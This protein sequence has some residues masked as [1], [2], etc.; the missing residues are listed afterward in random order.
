[1]TTTSNLSFLQLLEELL[2]SVFKAVFSLTPRNAS[3]STGRAAGQSVILTV[4]SCS[5]S[6]GTVLNPPKEG[7][8]QSDMSNVKYCY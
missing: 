2:E 8:A 1:M 6:N 3:G 4:N 7:A 5:Q